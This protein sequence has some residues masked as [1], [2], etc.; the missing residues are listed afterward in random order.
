LANP[1]PIIDTAILD[2][3]FLFYVQKNMV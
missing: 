3:L 2:L 1:L